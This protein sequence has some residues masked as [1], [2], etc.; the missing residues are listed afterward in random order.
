MT[1][2]K[3][4]E[5]EIRKIAD[6]NEIMQRGRRYYLNGNVSSLKVSE[7]KITAK[8]RGSY[9]EPYEVEL[10]IDDGEV[11][12]HFCDCPYYGEGCK[13][14]VAVLYKLLNMKDK[15][16]SQTN[17][18]GKKK[19][20]EIPEWAQSLT[21]ESIEKAIAGA[22][23]YS[24]NEQPR[25]GYSPH[26]YASLNSA[27]FATE[28]K[29]LR[30]IQL[31]KANAVNIDEIEEDYM[32][33]MVADGKNYNIAIDVDSWDNS[34]QPECD[35]NR[36]S[37]CG[38]CEHTAA[39]LL[40][41]LAKQGF[42][43]SKYEQKLK[44]KIETQ[45]FKSLVT[46]L[47]HIEPEIQRGNGEFKI[48]FNFEFA[49]GKPALSVQKAKLLKN[50]DY[51]RPLLASG[52]FVKSVLPGMPAKE[53]SAFEVFMS[54][55]LFAGGYGANRLTKSSFDNP[56][57]THIMG[58]IRDLYSENPSRVIGA[59]FPKEKACIK[60][61][62]DK[63]G[64][65]Y[66]LNISIL[67][68]DAP[69]NI[70]RGKYA[71]FGDNPSW[72]CIFNSGQNACYF[73]ELS[74][75][76]SY[77]AKIL[78]AHAGA[79]ISSRG[80]YE[81]AA[82][83]AQK[84]SGVGDINFPE[85]VFL[86]DIELE[87]KPRLF[88]N[89][90]AGVPLI[91]LRFLYGTE[92]AVYGKTGDIIASKDNNLRRIKRNLQKEDEFKAL[93]AETGAQAYNGGL[94][95]AS[96]LA[97][98][99]SD[100]G[101][102]LAAL[103]F[104][105]YG[106]DKLFNRKVKFVE[107][108][109][110]IEVSSGI[111]W[112][113]LKGEASFGEE[114]VPLANVLNAITNNERFVKLS[115]GTEGIIPKKWIDKLS[116]AS[117]LVQCGKDG[118][119]QAAKTQIAIIEQLLGIADKKAVDEE[120]SKIKER[121]SNFSEIKDAPLPASFKGSLREYQ[122]AG[123]NWMHFLKEFSFGGC[124]AD[125]MGLGKTVQALCM[126]L[127]EKEA[128]NKMRS[129]VVAPTSLIFNWVNE[130]EKF[131]PALEPYIHH[132][133]FREKTIN[134]IEKQHADLIVTTYGTL[135]NDT[136]IFKKMQFNYII[137][138]ESQSIKNP[139]S[140]NSKSVFGLSAKHRLVLTGTPIEN[141]TIELWSQFAFLNPGLLGNMEHFKRAFASRIENSKNK[142]KSGELRS[143]INPFILCRKKENVAKELPDKQ[144]TLL[145]CDMEPKQREVYDYWKESI[146]EDIKETIRTQGFM[147][148]RMKILAGLTKLRQVCNH[149][150][151]IDESYAGESGKFNALMEQIHS[152]ISG[153]HKALIF[154][155]FVKMLQVFK[156]YFEENNIRFSYLDGSTANRKQAVDLFQTD[157]GV[158]AFLI[159]L[160]A[161]G[162]GLNLTAADYV[163]IVDPWWNPAAEMQ[164]I[165][166]A[167]RIGQDKKVFVYKAITKDSVEE[168]I[169]ELQQKK[170]DMVKDIIAVED[171][172]FKRLKR[173][174]IMALFG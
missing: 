31:V 40:A 84:L 101:S 43:I 119:A 121:F 169:L 62:F 109:L 130:I 26:S 92:E 69:F 73:M 28:E 126:L 125:D 66:R 150:V 142:E 107:P 86:E 53:R 114:K 111:D 35:C 11:V 167:H 77:A 9:A 163:F 20:E 165:D 98:W 50:G 174:D 44:K 51:G 147:Q 138:D 78:F 122:K 120:F 63:D 137:L 25:N 156:R 131:T 145:H 8:V 117:G 65:G 90:E 13:H 4:S 70:S 140:K 38:K 37:R 23:S 97:S 58:L 113:D 22:D 81:F 21:P 96:D 166:R 104:E 115:D 91:E 19:K 94:H 80:F 15:I 106:A 30:A 148:S 173:E 160:K 116:S 129:L 99:L 154:S 143:I 56:L 71:I 164:A 76:S 79:L 36:Y 29:M 112:F 6:S 172:V 105:I 7:D 151:L 89:T 82:K 17:I 57:D 146:K 103:G 102:R 161:G 49:G 88:L 10:E 159:S 108:E 72:L 170:L 55:L 155:S 24:I 48:F 123:Y 52:E 41:L 162:L 60:I 152:V 14:V 93:L 2:L 87:P 32:E 134:K 168:K 34:I 110:K 16:L 144:V 95:T 64:K 74:S 75:E 1:K 124:L 136:E 12:D 39:A 42:D 139:L 127:H 171:G 68:G 5:R 128:G 59:V 45:K 47:E 118:N 149:P 157:E 83:Y 61:R 132:G 133:Q 18:S 54:S 3:I 27:N 141:N 33:A 158:K 67:A 135:R 46:C 100:N 85:K 153:G